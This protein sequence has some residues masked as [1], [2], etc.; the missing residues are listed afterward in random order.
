MPVTLVVEDGTGRA[1]ANAFASAEAVTERLALMPFATLWLGV[2]LDRQAQCIAEASAWL[3][4]EPWMGV[5]THE[6]QALAFPRSG[7]Q[8]PDGYAVA[9]DVLPS[10]LIDAVARLAYWL[11]QQS[12]TPFADSGLQPGSEL[13]LPGGFRMTIAAGATMPPDVRGLTRGYVR[14][15]STLVR[16]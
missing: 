15:S 11:S 16:A 2:D 3:S 10:W 9:S 5:R 12:A 6:T 8:T 7:M 13:A 1:D 14:S 4:R